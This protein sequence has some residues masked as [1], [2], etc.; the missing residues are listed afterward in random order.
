M[1]VPR[2]T[3]ATQLM[4]IEGKV[5]TVRRWLR[6]AAS[7]PAGRYRAVDLEAARAAVRQD[8]ATA[9]DRPPAGI[10]APIQA[11]CLRARPSVCSV[12]AL[13]GV[14][15]RHVGHQARDAGEVPILKVSAGRP[16]VTEVVQ[17]VDQFHDVA[18][19]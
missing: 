12:A 8:R 13:G 5:L 3:A 17:L 6:H 7:S 4:G 19:T 2:F 15:P 14:H 9:S 10:F 16:D 1:P 18:R 11:G